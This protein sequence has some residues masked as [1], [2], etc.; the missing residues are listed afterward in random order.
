MPVGVPETA[1]FSAADR[2]LARGERP[3]VE[4]VRAELGRGS[5]ARI[6]QLL[7]T[8]WDA[9]AQRL[10]GH[11]ALPALPE[12]VASAF[13]RVWE[14]AAAA[15]R[16]AAEHEVAGERAALATLTQTLHDE[17]GL[18][19]TALQEAQAE[20]RR[21]RVAS[22]DARQQGAELQRRI[23]QQVEELAA[24]RAQRDVLSARVLAGET[25]LTEV[26][27]QLAASRVDA[28]NERAEWGGQ[29]RALE[30]RAAREIDRARQE[31]KAVKAETTSAAKAMQRREQT[32]QRALQTAELTVA[33]QARRLAASPARTPGVRPKTATPK[34]VARRRH[35]S[36]GS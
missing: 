6:G 2:V 13:A 11:T 27:A 23:E 12:T 10:A 21:L 30:E 1:V 7:E 5:P 24:L 19:A 16:A 29:I 15:A 28:R 20:T 32:L 8:W 31:L 34:R 25:E 3:T 17:A 9:L 36:P 18:Q 22:D 4:R 26:R 14:Q 33:D 35:A